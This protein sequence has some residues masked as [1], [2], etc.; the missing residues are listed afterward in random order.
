[1]NAAQ[2]HLALNHLPLATLLFALVAFLI[3]LLGKKQVF[4]NTGYYLLIAAAILTIPV[5][6]SGEGTE[7]LAETLGRDHDL[8]HEHEETAEKAYPVV[9]ILGALALA[10]LIFQRLRDK[11][12]TAANWIAVLGTIAA[13][14]FMGLTAQQGGA[15]RH[16][17][18]LEAKEEATHEQHEEGHHEEGHADDD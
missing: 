18:I 1:M 15:I 8:I 2:I 14:Y 17:D 4:V 7:E 10:V 3:G 5:F 11:T 12:F 6:Q 9:L 16:N 13:L